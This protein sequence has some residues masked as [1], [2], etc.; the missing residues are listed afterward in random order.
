ML[1]TFHFQVGP[2]YLGI[3]LLKNFDTLPVSDGRSVHP[4]VSYLQLEDRSGKQFLG[5]AVE[6]QKRLS[7]DPGPWGR[8]EWRKSVRRKPRC[9]IRTPNRKKQTSRKCNTRHWAQSLNNNKEK[10]YPSLDFVLGSDR[11]LRF[12]NTYQFH[13]RLE[14]R[15]RSSGDWSRACRRCSPK[16]HD[17]SC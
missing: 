17:R 4:L 11:E 1:D 15:C 5:R 10:K 9:W 12:V 3:I 6:D 13:K 8:R 2:R 14:K 16:R 7:S